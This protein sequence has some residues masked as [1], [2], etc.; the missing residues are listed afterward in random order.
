[1]KKSVE[2]KQQLDALK[3]KMKDLMDAGKVKEAHDHLTEVED[4]KNQIEV[5]EMLERDEKENFSG[6]PV[7]QKA[8]AVSE[9]V[10]FNKRLLGKPLTPAE[11]TWLNTVGETGQVESV[12]DRGG[13][14]VPE[15]QQ[16][17]IKELKRQLRPLKDYCNVIPVGSRSGSMPLEV[18]ATDTLTAFDELS[19]ITQSD[20][21]F[22]Q[23]AWTA[24]DYGD[25]IPISNSLLA[26]ET[27]NLTDY[28]GRRFARK[29]VRTE[30]GK[31]LTALGGATA[32]T[33]TDYKAIKTML[34]KE[35]DP[36]IAAEAIIITN[37]SGFDWLDGLEDGNGH[38]LLQPML[39]DPTR[40][41]FSGHE[42]VVVTDAE[43]T[44]GGT[45]YVFYVV[46][47]REYLAFFDR[48]GVTMAVS[49]EAGFTKNATM[50]RVIERFDVQKVDTVAA[51]KLTITPPAESSGGGQ[52]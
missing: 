45:S 47:M 28:I 24:A 31:I 46:N 9:T 16:N 29:A 26:D 35:L 38:P 44:Q 19:E 17:Q 6:K 37:Q 3:N 20:I 41:A 10:V 22:A 21:S 33:G 1:M 52:G 49:T 36:A 23:V 32:K 13:Y 18:A 5:A 14:L 43:L 34:N 50:M 7:P 39:A 25:I 2:L 51:V 30:N 27:V 42:V 15:E 40:K 8:E 48:A 12:D 4:L 11:Q